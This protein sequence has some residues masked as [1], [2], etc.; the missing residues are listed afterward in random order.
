MREFALTPR[1]RGPVSELSGAVA[2]IFYMA[3]TSGTSV[4]LSAFDQFTSGCVAVPWAFNFPVLAPSRSQRY[5]NI[6]TITGEEGHQGHDP[7]MLIAANLDLL[8]QLKLSHPRIGEVAIV[9]VTRLV[10]PVPQLAPP[11]KEYLDVLRRPDMDSVEHNLYEHDGHPDSVIGWE[12]AVLI[13]QA[14]NL[15]LVWTV[16]RGKAREPDLLFQVLL[17]TLFSL[18][19]D[20]PLHTLIGDGLYDKEPVCRELVELWSI[21]PIFSR[22]TPRVTMATLRG[23][24]T[25][26]VVDGKPECPRCGPM[27][28]VRREGW[29]TADKRIANRKPRGE[30]VASIKTARTRWRC[31]CGLYSDVSLYARDNY[32]DHTF[33]PRDDEHNFGLERR[34]YELYRNGVESNFG[35]VKQRGI[36]TRDGRCLW[37]RD[38][39]IAVLFGAEQLLHTARRVAHE[40]GAYHLLHDEYLELGLNLSG[41]PPTRAHTAREHRVGR[42]LGREA[43]QA[44]VARDPLRLDD[45]GS[46]KRRGADVA[47]LPERIRSVSAESVSSMSVSCSGRWIW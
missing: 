14:S 10:A 24:S 1:A 35:R 39:G 8:R 27:K 12:G 3:A 41:E 6:K 15:P 31:L 36:G 25:V 22:R 44:A 21:Q 46:R 17:P 2:P 13:D 42:L 18:W 34:A 11:S 43:L 16:A 37:A 20:C 19:P 30:I 29:Y 28:F 7:G 32:R 47:D 40:T 45:L 5:R 23:G 9:D 33:W 38:S 4:A 26:V